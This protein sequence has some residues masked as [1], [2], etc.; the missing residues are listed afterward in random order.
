MD[1]ST[2][3]ARIKSLRWVLF[4]IPDNGAGTFEGAV[5]H[6]IEGAI[7]VMEFTIAALERGREK[8][9]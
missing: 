3:K 1:E 2:I 9:G 5:H 6:Y 7:E 4:N 8:N